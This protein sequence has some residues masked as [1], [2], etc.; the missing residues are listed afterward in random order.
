MVWFFLNVR[1][2]NSSILNVSDIF[3]TEI[4]WSCQNTF[5]ATLY[6][7]YDFVCR[8]LKT[9][10]MNESDTFNNNNNNNVEN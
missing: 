2:V 5:E 1:H 10:V 9:E 7:V 6:Q 3:L 4:L 8:K